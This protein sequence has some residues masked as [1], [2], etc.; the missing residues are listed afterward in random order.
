MFSTTTEYALRA[1]AALARVPR[2]TPMLA[3]ELAAA[4]DVPSSY[5]SKVLAQLVRARVIGATRGARGGYTLARPASA[6]YLS[7]VVQPFESNRGLTDCLFGGGRQ[8]SESAPCTAHAAWRRVRTAYVD[9][10]QETTLA[11][12]SRRAPPAVGLRRRKGRRARAG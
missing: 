4:A 2:G 9:F 6:I 12:V 3:R 1:L 5:L 10:L 7:E 8:C 11:D